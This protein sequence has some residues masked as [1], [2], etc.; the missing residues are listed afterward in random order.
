M[1]AS[2][3][4]VLA[5]HGVTAVVNCCTAAQM[6]NFFQPKSG[7]CQSEYAILILCCAAGHRSVCVFAHLEMTLLGRAAY[8]SD[9]R[10]CHVLCM[11]CATRESASASAP[12]RY[13][14][15][16]VSHW[17]NDAKS[18][19]PAW[20][21]RG[22]VPRHGF[23]MSTDAGVLGYFQVPDAVFLGGAEAA[24]KFSLSVLDCPLNSHRFGDLDPSYVMFSAHYRL[25]STLR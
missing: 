19:A 7:G 1:A 6:P 3:R 22:S 17:R 4:A 24:L 2:D 15:F 5:A 9:K 11:F 13:H 25:P 8:C 14:R 16:P 18:V 20:E 10:T 23:D 12:L 21:V